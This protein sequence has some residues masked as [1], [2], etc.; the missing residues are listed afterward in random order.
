MENLKETATNMGINTMN[1]LLDTIASKA[2]EVL[3]QLVFL[4]TVKSVIECIVGVLALL[5][6]Y[7]VV[8]Y[9]VAKPDESS[10]YRIEQW[11]NENKLPHC[12]G[13]TLA[14]AFSLGIG[15][16]LINIDWLYLLIAPKA[17]I[18]IELG[19]LL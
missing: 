10:N 15:I 1:D 14:A 19:K 6:T 7:L 13:V 11:L 12:L 18:L 17:Y 9:A 16:G 8:K 4:C 5:T 3:D 2:P